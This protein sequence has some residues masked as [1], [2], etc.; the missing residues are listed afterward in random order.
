MECYREHSIFQSG[1]VSPC[2]RYNILNVLYAY[3]YTVRLFNGD[4]HELC[5][6][7]SQVSRS[8]IQNYFTTYLTF[9]E[10]WDHGIFS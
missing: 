8:V 9:Q 6:Q 7:A 10:G 5:V 3:V 1:N 2:L 4:H